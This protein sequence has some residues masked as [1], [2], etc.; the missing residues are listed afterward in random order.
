[1]KEQ[2]YIL[3]TKDGTIHYDKPTR[4]ILLT[5]EELVKIIDDAYL[6]GAEARMKPF[7]TDLIG[8]K[9][10]TIEEFLREKGLL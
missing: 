7:T 3:F 2:F 10:Y 1:M 9:T 8:V 5:K 6:A 4:G